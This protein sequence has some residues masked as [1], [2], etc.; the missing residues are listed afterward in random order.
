[1]AVIELRPSRVNI[2]DGNRQNLS[3]QHLEFF[4]ARFFAT[5]QLVFCR[6]RLHCLRYE[7]I[8]TA[9][10]SFFTSNEDEADKSRLN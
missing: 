7:A 10:K 2:G 3:N 4:N 5:N 1:L 6:Q 8:L 9:A